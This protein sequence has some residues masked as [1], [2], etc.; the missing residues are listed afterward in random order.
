MGVCIYS[1]KN[2]QVDTTWGTYNSGGSTRSDWTY[3]KAVVIGSNLDYIRS[4]VAII[5]ISGNRIAIIRTENNLSTNNYTVINRGIIKT[6]IDFIYNRESNSAST[7][8]HVKQIVEQ[9]K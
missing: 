5:A 6:T 1:Q 4:I 3:V 9:T 8:V 7:K 2:R